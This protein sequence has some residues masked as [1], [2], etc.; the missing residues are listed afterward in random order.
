MGLFKKIIDAI[1]GGAREVGESI[2]DANGIRIFEQEVKDAEAHLLQ[3]K[4]DLTEVMAKEMQTGRKVED[5]NRNVIKHENYARQALEKSDETL[6]LE[7]AE[8]I[9]EFQSEITVQTKALDSFSAHAKRLKGMI[10]K[11]EKSLSDMKR[12]LVMVKTTDSVQK[13]TQTISDNYAS[14]GSKLLSAKDSLDRIQKRQEDLEDRLTAGEELQGEWSG[15]ALDDKL[16]EAGIGETASN[17]ND[18]LARL[19]KQA[20]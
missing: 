9:S 18:I 14:S 19:K 16:R 20:S 3:A 15:S 13:A 2:V 10:K 6:A 1:R 7:V 5:L 17:A 11:T 8:K 4:K 12:Q